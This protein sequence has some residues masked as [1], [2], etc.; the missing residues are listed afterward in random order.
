MLR[1]LFTL[2]SL[3]S[4]GLCLATVFLWLRSY[5][6]WDCVS[7]QFASPPRLNPDYRPMGTGPRLGFIV[8]HESATT[9][10]SWDGSLEVWRNAM[11]GIESDDVPLR[12]GGWHWQRGVPDRSRGPSLLPNMWTFAISCARATYP[13]GQTGT[14]I[15][16]RLPY[17]SLVIATGLLPAAWLLRA[18]GR[19]RSAGRCRRCGYDLRATPERCP[20]CGHVPEKVTA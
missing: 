18:R 3:L 1:R 7:G 13:A 11:R 16:I 20:E 4:L 6:V 17:W 15:Q 8:D 5:L 14:T 12:D 9:I 2:A 19:R 10:N